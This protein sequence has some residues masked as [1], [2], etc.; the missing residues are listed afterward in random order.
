M[1]H[2]A[3]ASGVGGGARAVTGRVSGPLLSSWV[4]NGCLGPRP[5]SP[6][7]SDAE[8]RP[9]TP[10]GNPVCTPCCGTSSESKD[11]VPHTD[12]HSHAYS[13]R[14]THVHSHS[15][16]HT[17]HTQTHTH[18]HS[19]RHIFTCAHT[20]THS[21]SQTQTHM[22]THMHRQAHM[23]TCAHTHTTHTQTCTR[24]EA[25]TRRQ[26]FTRQTLAHLVL[27]HAAGNRGTGPLGPMLRG[28]SSP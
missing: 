3:A 1:G 8:G 14:H 18:A 6:H 25:G 9:C 2:T 5:P 21:H 12:T 26:A 4:G 19:Y 20:D 11:S 22:H 13:H 16:T 10:H 7:L 27:T 17:C 24:T 23:H 28:L 15:N